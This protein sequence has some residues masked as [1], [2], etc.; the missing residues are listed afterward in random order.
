MSSTTPIAGTGQIN[1]NGTIYPFRGALKW[2]FQVFKKTGIV[3]RDGSVHGTKLDP[4]TPYVEGD[5]TFDGSYT[6]A[7]LEAIV[8]GTLSASL[9][10]GMQLVLANCAVEGD[11]EPDGDEGQLKIRFIGTRGTELPAAA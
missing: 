1:V 4:N 11:I 8:N 9:A 5:F 2:N 6:T 10:T 3:G 7:Q